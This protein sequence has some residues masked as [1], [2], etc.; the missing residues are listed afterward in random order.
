MRFR[1]TRILLLA[2]SMV[3]LLAMATGLNAQAPAPSS[4][5]STANKS[6]QKHH[7]KHNKTSEAKPAEPSGRPDETDKKAKPVEINI[8]INIQVNSPQSPAAVSSG[9][10]SGAS[11]APASAP[12]P[13]DGATPMVDKKDGAATSTNPK[14]GCCICIPPPPPSCPCFCWPSPNGTPADMGCW[15]PP[16]CG[17]PGY[18]PA[19]QGP[20]GRGQ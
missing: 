11:V 20:G 18:G 19:A 12:K 5:D 7:G 17:W 13:A 4:C 10:Q 16:A 1:S 2:S 14:C 3:I 15:C 9:S 8:A 6:N